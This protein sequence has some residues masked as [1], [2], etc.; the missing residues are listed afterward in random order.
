MTTSSNL[1]MGVFSYFADTTL[2]NSFHV[3]EIILLNS[4]INFS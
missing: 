2:I 3:P 4:F 1:D